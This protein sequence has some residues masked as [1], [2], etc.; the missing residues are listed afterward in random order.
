MRW[1][2][3]LR[4]QSR[5]VDSVRPIHRC[6]RSRTRSGKRLSRRQSE[7]G[8]VRSMRSIDAVHR[9]VWM[10]QC[11]RSLRSRTHSVTRSDG[12]SMIFA[13]CRLPAIDS[14]PDVQ[15][16]SS[17]RPP[18]EHRSGTA[19]PNA[20]GDD[21][22]LGRR[23]MSL[24]IAQLRRPDGEIH[25]SRDRSAASELLNNVSL[26]PASTTTRE[27]LGQGDRAPDLA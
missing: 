17:S 1:K 21:V 25:R 4:T 13:I 2:S 15:A 5:N 14:D 8:R 20:R 12:R 26:V 19:R 18:S 24:L 9:T 11:L 22:L 27:G 3:L 10:A 23:R 7:L 6:D 16:W